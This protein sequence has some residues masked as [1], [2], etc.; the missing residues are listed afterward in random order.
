MTGYTLVCVLLSHPVLYTKRVWKNTWKFEQNGDLQFWR[1]PTS[2][3]FLDDS[4]CKFRFYWGNLVWLLLFGSLFHSK[5]IFVE[6]LEIIPEVCPAHENVVRSLW[7][8]KKV[9]KIM[10]SLIHISCCSFKG[11]S[12]IA[13]VSVANKIWGIWWCGLFKKTNINIRRRSLS[14]AHCSSPP[15]RDSNSIGM[16]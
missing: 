15:V 3:L 12:R 6:V 16:K 11:V 5:E 1:F 14:R 2:D 4:W 13:M 9:E 8:P 10:K 7:L